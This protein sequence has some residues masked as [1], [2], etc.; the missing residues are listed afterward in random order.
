MFWK[1]KKNN[2]EIK[3]ER[4]FL[5]TRVIGKTCTTCLN[6]KQEPAE[7]VV[8]NILRDS[9]D[10]HRL[11]NNIY[12][13]NEDKSKI[14]QVDHIA[15][16]RNYIY[17]IETKDVYG[18]PY[19]G[20]KTEE[21]WGV[22]PNIDSHIYDFW[23]QGNSHW[24]KNPYKQNQLHVDFV[25]ELLNNEILSKKVINVIVYQ[26]NQAKHSPADIKEKID[27]SP[28]RP[29]ILLTKELMELINN[30]EKANEEIS[31]TDLDYL[32]NLFDK[33]TNPNNEIMKT[34]LERAIEAESTI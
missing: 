17:V 14:Y 31:E 25:K 20:T 12:L 15:I 24:I 34:H 26:A 19:I 13:W 7:Q 8:A 28:E 4:K 29:R 21:Y 23:Y 1:K 27:V 6:G 22:A 33:Y 9:G 2:T 32:A 5:H 30:H 11:Y 3:P 16:G 18:V 10:I